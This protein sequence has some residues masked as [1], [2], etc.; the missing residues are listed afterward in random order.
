MIYLA[1]KIKEQIKISIERALE[2]LSLGIT[3][4]ELSHPENMEF[5]DYATTAAIKLAKTSGDNPKELAEKIAGKILSYKDNYIKNVSAVGGF[6][7]FYL[8]EKFFKESAEEILKKGDEYGKNENLKG[9]KVIVEYTDPNPFKAFHIGHLM[10]NTIGEALARIV[11][12]NGAEV[13]RANYQGDVGMHVA[14]AVWGAMHKKGDIADGTAYVAGAT[15]FLD[16]EYKKEITEIN[17]KIYENSD[18][19]INKIYEEGKKRSLENF[20]EMYEKLGTKFDFYFFENEMAV[21][22]KKIVE[23]NIGKVFKK[24]EGAVVFCGEKYDAKL[25]TRVFINSDGIPTYEAKDLGLIKLK[26]EKYDY[27]QSVVVTGNEVDEYF[28]VVLKAMELI[29]PELRK[30]TMH[31][32]HGMLKLPSGKMSSRTGEVITAEYLIEEVKKAIR[33]NVKKEGFNEELWSKIADKVAVGAIK[34]SILRQAAGK[35]IIFDFEK[36]LSFQGDSGPY[37]QYTYARMRSVLKKAEEAGVKP[38][39][40]GDF[41]ENEKKLVKIL[42]RWPEVIERA[43]NDYAPHYIATYLIK[44]ASVF[45]EYYA[46][47]KIISEE[48]NSAERVAVT[49][50]SSQ[51]IKNGLGFLGIGILDRM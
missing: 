37:L 8:S 38:V 30:K 10:S 23:E 44:V 6:V 5:G 18:E 22:G 20:E 50:A 26:S 34:Y 36:T 42:C 41:E 9:Q 3:E 51:V 12:A 39:I 19:E 2:E 21:M 7:N 1:E 33:E 29:Y 35:D 13:K 14:K 46:S 11:E 32:S 24:S 31:I 48:K 40:L 16:E 28:K 4:V 43:L 27:D 47:N 15:A 45:N 25:H 49:L 17:K